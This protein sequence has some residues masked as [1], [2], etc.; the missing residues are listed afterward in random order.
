[1]R[2][3]F[4]FVSLPCRSRGICESP[5]AFGLWQH[6]LRSFA[7]LVVLAE[8]TQPLRALDTLVVQLDAA[9]SIKTSTFDEAEPSTNSL[10]TEVPPISK[11]SNVHLT[12]FPATLEAPRGTEKNLFSRVLQVS[13]FHRS[14]VRLLVHWNLRGKPLT[15]CEERNRRKGND[16]S[17]SRREIIVRRAIP[18]KRSHVLDTPQLMKLAP[19]DRSVVHDDLLRKFVQRGAEGWVQRSH[20]ETARR[21]DTEGG[22]PSDPA[23]KRSD[24]TLNNTKQLRHQCC[25]PRVLWCTACPAHTDRSHQLSWDLCLRGLPPMKDAQSSRAWKD[26]LTTVPFCFEYCRDCKLQGQRLC[27]SRRATW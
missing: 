10:R 22:A 5:H 21:N 20:R 24:A 23:V 7:C 9:T 12:T 26:K 16:R 18:R 6:R 14:T 3:F 13:V 4:S 11:P 1:M 15:R 27:R 19:Q 8:K 25:D 2:I 17:N